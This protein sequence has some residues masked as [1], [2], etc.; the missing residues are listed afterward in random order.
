VSV[1]RG[2]LCEPVHRGIRAW[3]VGVVLGTVPALP[4]QTLDGRN[5]LVREADGDPVEG[6]QHGQV[7]DDGLRLLALPLDSLHLSLQV[8]LSHVA[9]SDERRRSAGVRALHYFA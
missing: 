1:P 4:E 8:P 7:V 3:S 9:L 6:Q 2:E 5:D